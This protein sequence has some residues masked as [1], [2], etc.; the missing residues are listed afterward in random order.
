MYPKIAKSHVITATSRLQRVLPVTSKYMLLTAIHAIRCVKPT[1]TRRLVQLSH[2]LRRA[3]LAETPRDEQEYF[4]RVRLLGATEVQ[5]LQQEQDETI[6]QELRPLIAAGLIEVY[7]SR[8]LKSLRPVTVPSELAS[9]SLTP[10]AD[11]TEE[12]AR[13]AADNELLQCALRCGPRPCSVSHILTEFPLALR[14]LPELMHLLDAE[15][16]SATFRK[17]LLS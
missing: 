4:T 15:P 3:N 17:D 8:F 2:E 7:H 5:R 16:N 6:W 1:T 12:A 13:V 9:D 14:V 10:S 11:R